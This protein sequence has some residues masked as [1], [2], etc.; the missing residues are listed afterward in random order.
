VTLFKPGELRIIILATLGITLLLVMGILI[1]GRPA[2]EPLPETT[3]QA[4]GSVSRSGTL[5]LSDFILRS[6]GEEADESWALAR[7]PRDSWSPGE[8]R[9]FWVDP[10]R[11]G[12]EKLEKDNDEL[13]R[14]FFLSVE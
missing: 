6:A 5:M 13:V 12:L 14:T 7:P 3:V 9:R 11:A 4:E 1:F 10:A 8:I 2:K